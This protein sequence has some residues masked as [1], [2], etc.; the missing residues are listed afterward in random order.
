MEQGLSS[1]GL[2]VRGGDQV[3]KDIASVAGGTMAGVKAQRQRQEVRAREN[4]ERAETLLG[5]KS[6]AFFFSQFELLPMLA[7]MFK[8]DKLRHRLSTF[9]SAPAEALRATRLV[10][11]LHAPANWFKAVANHSGQVGSARG[12]RW[13]KVA[14]EKA[15]RWEERAA[16][17]DARLAE[18]T[19]GMRG[20]I[21][22][23]LDRIGE[24]SVGGRLHGWMQGVFKSSAERASGREAQAAKDA[25]HAVTHESKWFGAR[26]FD[27][28][29]GRAPKPVA[30]G[31]LASHYHAFEA[32]GNL[33]G[34]AKVERLNQ[35][36]D[37]LSQQATV[38]AFEGEASNRASALL[39]QV[40]RAARYAESG[41]MYGSAA[42]GSLSKSMGV[43]AKAAGRV[44][45]L[46]AL[47]GLGVAAGIGAT[48]VTHR[49]DSDAAKEALAQLKQD[50]EG[51]AHNPLLKAVE[52]SYVK[53]KGWRSV[54]TGIEAAGTVAD[55]MLFKDLHNPSTSLVMT[56]M[57]PF[58]THDL[59]PENRLLSAYAALNKADAGELQLTRE[60]RVEALRELIG[61]MPNVVAHGG[62]Y[63]RLVRP[64]AEEMVTREMSAKQV[65]QLLADERG[66][67]ML[68]DEVSRKREAALKEAKAKAAAEDAPPATAKT[69]ATPVAPVAAPAAT[70]E[71][72]AESA[73]HAAE[74]PQL[75]VVSG[76]RQHEGK[77]SELALK[78]A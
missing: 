70:G 23:G 31:E 8:A 30:M 7:M 9:L 60:Q 65:V 15:A 59:V 1:Q 53:Q 43:L 20:G 41:H 78:R 71:T 57:L 27:K 26:M 77:V 17:G 39:K 10:D 18:A 75:A 29:R 12:D 46:G 28:I 14:T 22:R 62:V 21:G 74:K 49:Q 36:A 68:T 44:P 25:L 33:Q 64:I 72:K 73:Y 54:K 24:T 37:S 63:N 48:Y 40:K 69:T 66:F 5:I 76:D 19:R 16:R 32:A 3:V 38:N 4:H 47:L 35:L 51:N 6:K 55:G 67:T 61:V 45:V 11:I 34:A 13:A 42:E 56:Q 52:A 58:L 2:N 50:L